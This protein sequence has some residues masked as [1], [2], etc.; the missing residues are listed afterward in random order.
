[1]SKCTTFQ[2][3]VRKKK[4]LNTL[5][6]TN[7]KA[8]TIQRETNNSPSSN[9]TM[10]KNMNQGRSNSIS[11]RHMD[12]QISIKAEMIKE[13]MSSILKHA[14]TL[15]MINMKDV[16]SIL[17]SVN[18]MITG[19]TQTTISQSTINSRESVTHITN[20]LHSKRSTTETMIDHMAQ[21][22]EAVVVIEEV[23]EEVEATIRSEVHLIK[24]IE[25]EEEED[26]TIAQEAVVDIII[27]TMKSE[28]TKIELA[29]L[30]PISNKIL[31]FILL[32]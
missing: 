15:I 18:T 31:S 25:A 22:I 10:S 12:R 11:Q 8:K 4:N 3:K 20:N 5:K 23:K 19:R 21:T 27:I 32:D 28:G 17:I 26:T 30:N 1:M 14:K 6:F 2:N 7:T 29:V 16:S 13:G 24:N 9:N